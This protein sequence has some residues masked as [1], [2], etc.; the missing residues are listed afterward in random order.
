SAQAA[1]DATEAELVSLQAS[2]AEVSQKV[3]TSTF[4]RST[5][6]TD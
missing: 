1:K 5:Y 6:T 3:A 4:C 2:Y